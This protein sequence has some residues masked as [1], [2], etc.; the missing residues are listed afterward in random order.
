MTEDHDEIKDIEDVPEYEA[1][2][3]REIVRNVL[4]HNIDEIVVEVYR[5][6][7]KPI[8]S[9]GF[10]GPLFQ[11]IPQETI[12]AL[13]EEGLDAF[14]GG[15][16][17]SEADEDVAIDYASKYAFAALSIRYPWVFEARRKREL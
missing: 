14:L 5:N 13:Y 6:H 7:H 17:A 9:I 4:E 10:G 15:R 2:E 11:E 16:D 3:L 12:N 1:E 8:S